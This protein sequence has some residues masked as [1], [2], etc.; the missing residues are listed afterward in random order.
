MKKYSQK[1]LVAG[2][3]N[4]LFWLTVLFFSPLEVFFR[5]LE[6]FTFPVNHVWWIMLLLAVAITLVVSFLEALL[7][8]KAVIWIA[9]VTL[10]GGICFYVQ[11]LFLNGQMMEM[12]GE[13][14]P[15]TRETVGKNLTIWAMIAICFLLLCIVL[16][17]HAGEAKLR[18]ILLLMSAALIII[19]ASGLISTRMSLAEEDLNKDLYLSTQGEFDLSPGRNVLYFIL[20]TCDREYVDAALEAD[21][22]LFKEFTGFTNYRNSTS[23]YSRTYPALPFLLTGEK[24]YFD[25][26]EREYL[27]QAY[28]K[29]TFIPTMDDAGV[30]LRLYTA[31]NYLDRDAYPMV[32]NVTTYNSGALS[33]LSIKN[34]VKAMIRLGGYREMPYLLKPFFYYTPDPINR[35]VMKTLPDHYFTMT[36]ND[37]EFYE[38]LLTEQV[39]VNEEIDSAFRLYHLFGPHPGCYMNERAEYDPNAS[40]TDAARGD[41]LI[42]STYIRFLKESGIYDNTAIV[43]TADHGNQNEAEDLVLHSPP[44]CVMLFKPVGADST[45]PMEISEA[46]VCHDDLFAAVLEQL[47]LDGSAYPSALYTHEEGEVRERIYYYTAQRSWGDGEVALREYSIRGDAAELSNWTLTGNDWD[48]LYSANAVSKERLPRS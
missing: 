22:E 6:E 41:F 21:P 37:F 11:M 38:R 2:S 36:N 18:E 25:L 45:R 35:N 40:Q 47:E 16:K 10:L 42:L 1:F 14:V 34:L 30:D 5:N 3:A 8:G 39:T 46:P 43:V 26:P 29:G 44:C 15:F 23:K 13:N 32:D 20:D 27:R 4:L 24:C 28:E 31:L 17:R 19:Q 12:M 7:P 48:I 9:V 33:I